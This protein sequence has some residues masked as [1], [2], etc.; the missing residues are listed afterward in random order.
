MQVETDWDNKYPGVNDPLYMIWL[1]AGE[2]FIV[3]F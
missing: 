2:L 3:L 1:G